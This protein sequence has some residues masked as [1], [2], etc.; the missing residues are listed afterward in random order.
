MS[1][2]MSDSGVERGVLMS[3]FMRNSSIKFIKESNFI[4][5]IYR[6]PTEEE[7]KEHSRFLLLPKITV[8]DLIAFV[9][10][11]QPDAE[12]RRKVGLNVRVGCFTPLPGGHHI[13][14]NLTKLLADINETNHHRVHMRYEE[15]HPFTDGN[16]RSGRVLWAWQ[17]FRYTGIVPDRFLQSFYYDTLKEWERR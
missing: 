17:R 6:E 4:E 11:Y 2:Y 1:G 8:Q 10:T 13:E 7:I 5:G 15:L 9:K 12:L 14:I 3:M 16:G